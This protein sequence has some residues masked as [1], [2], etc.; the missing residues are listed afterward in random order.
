[1]WNAP[2]DLSL[3]SRVTAAIAGSG[4]RRDRRCGPHERHRSLALPSP[5]LSSGETRP[6]K[7]VTWFGSVS[8][9][10]LDL[11]GAVEH[12]P[13]ME[14]IWSAIC[15]QAICFG[16]ICFGTG[17]RKMSLRW[18]CVVV[19]GLALA[20][21]AEAAEPSGLIHRASCSVVRFYV[22]KFSASAAEMWAR[23]HGATEAEIEAA[24]RCL[25]G[26]PT[27]SAQAAQW[28]AQ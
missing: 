13:L 5:R 9:N 7:S 18:G 26:A 16:T 1:M 25:K 10:S 2:H 22:A 23:S 15:S 4:M 14:L 11:T 8:R 6:C 3:K 19:I 17:V 24:R 20:P 12:V 27:Q 28:I 21:R